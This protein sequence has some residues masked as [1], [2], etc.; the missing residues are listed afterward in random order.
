MT[1]PRSSGCRPATTRASSIPTTRRDREDRFRADWYLDEAKTELD[2]LPKIRNESISAL[3]CSPTMELGIDIGGLSVVHMRNAPPNAA[4]YAQRS[5]RAGRSGQGA[6]I[7]T[8][9]SSYSP[10]DRHYFQHQADLVAGVV[11]APRLDLCNRELLATHLNA[12]SHLGD[13][14]PGLGSTGGGKPSLMHLV[15]DDNDKM[16]LAPEVRAGLQLAPGQYATH[17]QHCSSASFAT[18]ARS[19]ERD[20]RP[21]YTD[22]WIDQQSGQAGRTA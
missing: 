14:L 15:E 16:P 22:Q 13:R 17:R 6:L 11:Q 9:C 3:F 19:L 18:L 4:N 2:D 12:L 10:H 20:A 8:Y 21:W 5:G 7:F 1:L